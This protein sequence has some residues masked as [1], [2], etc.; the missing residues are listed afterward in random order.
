MV[1]CD[2]HASVDYG[3]PRAYTSNPFGALHSAGALRSESASIKA[4]GP[5]KY[6]KTFLQILRCNVE[7]IDA[8]WCSF[9]ARASST[10]FKSRIRGTSQGEKIQNRDTTLEARRLGTAWHRHPPMQGRDFSRQ[11]IGG[12]MQLGGSGSAALGHS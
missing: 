8:Y 10:P 2:K 1:V 9:P 5:W 6:V 7:Q 4:L 12:Y 3:S 11:M